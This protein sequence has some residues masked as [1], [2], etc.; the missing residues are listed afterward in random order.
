MATA[1][2]DSPTLDP[3]NDPEIL[4]LLASEYAVKM[5]E[6]EDCFEKFQQTISTLRQTLLCS[7]CS[8]LVKSPFTCSS[9]GK[10]KCKSCLP[11]QR[12]TKLHYCICSGRQTLVEEPILTTRLSS[13]QTLCKFVAENQLPTLATLPPLEDG[14]NGKWEFIRTLLQDAGKEELLETVEI[15]KSPPVVSQN[16][17]ISANVTTTSLQ[18][19]QS[20]SNKNVLSPTS[21]S[22]SVAFISKVGRNGPNLPKSSQSTASLVETAHPVQTLSTEIIT[23]AAST[24]AKLPTQAP[25]RG[26]PLKNR[27]AS[28][29]MLLVSPSWNKKSFSGKQIGSMI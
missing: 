11:R 13:Y 27:S 4:L 9:C 18:T 1:E 24:S 28:K 10:H 3:E 8:Q 17:P 20:R 26:S 12:P 14:R 23:P 2:V 25:I 6:S 16:G 5:L 19:P 7:S 29:A 21:F 22:D 15:Q